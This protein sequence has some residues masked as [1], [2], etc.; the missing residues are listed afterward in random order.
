[1]IVPLYDS[2]VGWIAVFAYLISGKSIPFI[3]R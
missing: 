2:K 3:L 1:M